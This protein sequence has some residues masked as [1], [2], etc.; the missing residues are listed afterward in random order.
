[1]IIDD[2]EGCHGIH[3]FLPSFENQSQE[4]LTAG[5]PFIGAG[6][7]GEIT[8]ATLGRSITAGGDTGVVVRSLTL[9]L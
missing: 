9:R 3:G 6:E 7:G 8:V 5:G 2:Q 4:V 1:M